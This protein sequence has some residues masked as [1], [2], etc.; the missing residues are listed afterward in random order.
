MSD[1]RKFPVYLLFF[2]IALTS[3]FSCRS[4]DGISR[5]VLNAKK[6]SIKVNKRQKNKQ[7]Q[8]TIINKDDYYN[9]NFLRYE[10]YVYDANIKTVLLHPD[11]WELSSP[12]IKL[13]STDK[14]KLSFDDF[15]TNVKSYKFTVVHCN[16][17]WTPSDLLPSDYIDGFTDDNINSY[18]YSLNTMQKYIHYDL[19]F[20][21]ENLRLTKS[22]NYLLK[23]FTESDPETPVITQRFMVM[24]QQVNI[25][26]R[27]KR[28]TVL[29]DMDYKQ[30]I[31]FTI[32]SGAYNIENPYENIHV[33]ITQNDR[34]D[35]AITNLKPLYVRGS[36]LIYDFEEGNVFTGGSEFRR[37]DVKSIQYYSERIAKISYDS[38]GNHV[39]LKPDIRN[40]FKVY[41]SDKDI[42]GKYLIKT[43][44]GRNTDIEADYLWVHFSL[45]YDAPLVDGDLYV[46]GELTNWAFTKDAKLKYDY[47][48][49]TY[50]TAL[51]L[52]QG[53]YNYEYLF[54]KNSETVGDVSFIEG[55]H[56]ETENDYNIFVYYRKPGTLY[57]QL[58]AVK[59]LNSLKDK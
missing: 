48:Q 55:T 46:M 53:Y 9:P 33:A 56:Y 45:P 21:T 8:D 35:N 38:L 10:N 58:I 11:G 50:K 29:N 24:D 39:Y 20:P 22:G 59:K 44:D 17:D 1:I 6:D 52:K 36:E 40:T 43:E 42:N 4:S 16:A 47:A 19:I 31:D 34:I 14:L 3:A 37:F 7:K 26:G 30:E 2:C 5:E 27:V 15:V 12:V 57:D 18:Q 54:L 51:Y 41:N 32:N 23:V 25:A 13:N 28:A 49:K